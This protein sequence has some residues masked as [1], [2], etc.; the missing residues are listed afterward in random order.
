MPSIL[1][2]AGILPNSSHKKY[3]G[4]SNFPEVFLLASLVKNL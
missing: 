1:G 2:I 4:R 3:T